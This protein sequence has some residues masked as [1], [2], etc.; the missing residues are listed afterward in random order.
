MS[1]KIVVGRLIKISKQYC[2]KEKQGTWRKVLS[3]QNILLNFD[4]SKVINMKNKIYTI[5]FKNTKK[6]K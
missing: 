5:I 1:Q 2:S 4:D 6:L 3:E